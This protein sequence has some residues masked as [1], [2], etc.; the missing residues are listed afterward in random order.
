MSIPAILLAALLAG[1]GTFS[2]HLNDVIGG[3]PT[4]VHSTA[5]TGTSGST[6]PASVRGGGPVGGVT[7]ND[8]AGGGPSGSP[9]P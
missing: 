3:G 9:H 2:M 4:T 7:V 6:H 5:G 1:L 8:V